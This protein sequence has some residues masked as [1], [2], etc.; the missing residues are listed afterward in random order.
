M[1]SRPEFLKFV[2]DRVGP[3]QGMGASTLYYMNI[4]DRF[5][6]K[7]FFA[8]WN[9]ASFFWGFLGLEVVWMLYRRMY[10]YA[11][12]YVLG[13]FGV[14][15]MLALGVGAFMKISL[16]TLTVESMVPLLDVLKHCRLFLQMATALAFGVWGNA[17]YFSNIRRLFSKGDRGSQAGTN[18]FMALVFLILLLV[19]PIL[20][21]KVMYPS[22]YGQVHGSFL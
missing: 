7:K 14:V 12:L 6:P 10:L 5:Y 18:L 2:A 11:G 8:S 9:W 16:A 13:L 4:Y 1:I 21:L 19:G 20:L 22:L 17:L 3:F 15:L